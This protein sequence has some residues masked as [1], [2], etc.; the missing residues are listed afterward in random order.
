MIEVDSLSVIDV[1]NIA[2]MHCRAL[3]DLTLVFSGSVTATSRKKGSLPLHLED[4]PLKILKIYGGAVSEKGLVDL[5]RRMPRLESL[6][7][8]PHVRPR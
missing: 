5:V 2:A 4:F 1:V 6:R 3:E 8:G 7:V